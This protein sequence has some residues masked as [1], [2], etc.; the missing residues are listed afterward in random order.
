MTEFTTPGHI[1]RAHSL[2][3]DCELDTPAKPSAIASD[4][5]S[6]IVNLAFDGGA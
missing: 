3:N 6:C 2:H 1:E 5:D 4:Q